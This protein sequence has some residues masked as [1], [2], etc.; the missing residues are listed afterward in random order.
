MILN[1]SPA[2]RLPNNLNVSFEGVEGEALLLALGDVAV[3]TGSACAS[4]S[5][6]PSHVLAAIGAGEA[7]ARASLRF[8]LGR[9]NTEADVDY[10][11][12]RVATV[13]TRLRQTSHPSRG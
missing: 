12:D 5:Q 9:A 10:V 6:A 7:P 1:G 4:A 8:G 3:S 13:V 2:A 11:V